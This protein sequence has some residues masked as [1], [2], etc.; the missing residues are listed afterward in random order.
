MV[1]AGFL[2]YILDEYTILYTKVIFGSKQKRVV[3][4]QLVF[5]GGNST[6]KY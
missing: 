2:I 3:N 1:L 4:L 5:F 6:D